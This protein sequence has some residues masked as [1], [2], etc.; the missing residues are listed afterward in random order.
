MQILLLLS[1]LLSA[2]TGAIAGPRVMD[3][4][5][6]QAEARIVAPARPI[7]GSEAEEPRASEP[8]ARIARRSKTLLP[9]PPATPVALPLASV[10][11]IE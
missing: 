2:V 1:A 5:V 10:C 6:G 11:L 4:Q 3:G 8:C 7:A 9:A